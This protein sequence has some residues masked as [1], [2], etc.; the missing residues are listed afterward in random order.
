MNYYDKAA[1]K[2]LYFGNLPHLRQNTVCYFVTFRTA[3]SIPQ[4]KLQQWIQDRNEWFLVHPEPLSESEKAEYK[5]LFS[6]KIEQWLDCNYGECLL[7]L[8]EC[9]VIMVNAL[10]FFNEQRYKLW[11][12]AVAA[13][14][15]HLLIEPLADNKLED[16]MRSLKSFTAKEI[17]KALGRSGHFWQKEYF[18]HIVRSEE[19]YRKFVNYIRKHVDAR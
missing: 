4:A 19:H 12:Y 2:N 10:L 18:D 13:N 8:E 11:E 17:N 9:K 5:R 7:A 6:R 1:E 14:H 16:I 3:D 15:V